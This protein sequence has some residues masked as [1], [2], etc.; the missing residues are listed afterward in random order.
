MKVVQAVRQMFHT[1]RVGV[2]RC[3]S[4]S[5]GEQLCVRSV[6]NELHFYEND[7]FSKNILS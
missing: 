3:P 7:D 4:W 5:D 1:L 6:N 2:H